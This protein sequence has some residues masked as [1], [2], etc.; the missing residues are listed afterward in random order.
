M[1]S[2]ELKNNEYVRIADDV[3]GQANKTLIKLL[4]K[5]AVQQKKTVDGV[6]AELS[7]STPSARK[8][9]AQ[10]KK[11][12]QKLA[13]V[14]LEEVDG[15]VRTAYTSTFSRTAEALS[16]SSPSLLITK[17]LV[18]EAVKYKVAGKDF[19]TRIW[20]DVGALAADLSIT[21]RNAILTGEAPEKVA[22]KIKKRY[23]TSAYN[24][25]RLVNT[26]VAR[27]VSSAQLTAY[28]ESEVVEQ[29]MYTAT[30]EKNTCPRCAELDGKYF[31][32]KEVPS[33][34]LH[35]NCRCCFV[36]VISGYTLKMRTRNDDK[37][38]T[39]IKYVNYS[40]WR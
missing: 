34:P 30:L 3:E 25:K 21:I 20:E 4:Q 26:E 35:P 27:V 29:V 33:I 24:A 37:N 36:P 7:S 14:E 5:Y 31:N 11:D 2:N 23:N 6:L 19:S 28:N 22:R 13:E 8:L 10:L 40:N 9:Q 15:I 12:L 18:E 17:E 38:A 1:S 39:A 32:K 16:I